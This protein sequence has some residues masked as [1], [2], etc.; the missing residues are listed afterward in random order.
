MGGP[1][2]VSLRVCVGA[3]STTIFWVP[4]SGRGWWLSQAGGAQS[5]EGASP[6]SEALPAASHLSCSQPSSQATFLPA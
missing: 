5:K 2:G 4:S 1:E 3:E 6:W